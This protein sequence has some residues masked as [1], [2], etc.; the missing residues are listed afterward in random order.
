MW[1]LQTQ[2]PKP[3]IIHAAKTTCACLVLNSKTQMGTRPLKES[4]DLELFLNLIP[5]PGGWQ[6]LFAVPCHSRSSTQC[7]AAPGWPRGLW[8]A[9]PA[10]AARP[11]LQQ[12]SKEGIG[13]CLIMMLHLPN[14]RVSC[15]E[16][17]NT[18][19]FRVW[20]NRKENS[21]DIDTSTVS[22]GN[23]ASL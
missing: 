3:C 19:H 6:F 21:L 22:L 9:A 4:P 23:V 17:E 18:Q 10:L 12:R 16:A 11:K 13:L 7:Q 14:I 15:G 2:L 20:C 1:P 8:E 5:A